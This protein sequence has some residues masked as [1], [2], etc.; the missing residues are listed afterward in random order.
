[1]PETLTVITSYLVG[2]VGEINTG[3]KDVE[4]SS[5]DIHIRSGAQGL[6]PCHPFLIRTRADEA[7][8]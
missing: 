3:K 6:T 8:Y 5:G 1:M 4:S 7:D 2:G